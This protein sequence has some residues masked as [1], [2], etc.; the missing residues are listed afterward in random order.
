[1]DMTEILRRVDH[2]DLR[3]TAT[4]ANICELCADAAKYRTASVCVP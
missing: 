4:E 3:V 1:M 2:T